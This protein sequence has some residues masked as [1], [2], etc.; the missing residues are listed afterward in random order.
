MLVTPRSRIP[1]GTIK[2]KS[3]RS[4]VT[5]RAKPWVVTP[6]ATCT[7]SAAIFFSADSTSGDGPD[8]GAPGRAL[9][10][11][12]V[13][14]T[15]ANEYFFQA[16][17]V[18]HNAQRRGKAAQMENGITHQLARTVIGDVA[19]AVGLKQGDAAAGQ[20]LVAG[21]HVLT[22]GIPAQGE[23]R[24]MFDQQEHI[25]DALLLAQGAQLLLQSQR[26]CVIQAAEMEQGHNHN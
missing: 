8:A 17:K 21:H 5:F 9:G 19:S 10:K 12:A 2:A 26:R 18:L 14:R 24:G 6:R 16:A 13:V 20:Q 15:G 11:H 25:A 1:Q 23:H 3:S 22:V 4:V 7:P